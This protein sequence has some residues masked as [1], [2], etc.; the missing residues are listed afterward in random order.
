MKAS[1]RIIVS[2]II[3][4]AIMSVQAIAEPPPPQVLAG[5]V[6]ASNKKPATIPTSSTTSTSKP[7]SQGTNS[8]PPQIAALAD[9]AELA[10]Y[11]LRTAREVEIGL[12]S[13]AMIG[14][15][16]NKTTVLNGPVT[17][18]AIQQAISAANLQIDLSSLED[19]YYNVNVHDSNWKVSLWGGQSKKPVMGKAG[20]QA[21]FVIDLQL[22]SE[23]AI[24]WNGLRDVKLTSFD[25]K[26]KIANS[27]YLDVYPDGFRFPSDAAGKVLIEIT[28]Q[29]GKTISYD[30]RKSAQVKEERVSAVVTITAKNIESITDKSV[31]NLIPNTRNGVGD[32]VL[33]EIILTKET[34]V[35]VAAQTI[36][37]GKATAFKYMQ[38]GVDNDFRPAVPATNGIL[39]LKLTPGVWHII[40]IFP[41]DVLRPPEFIFSGYGGGNGGGKG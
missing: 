41:S 27:W 16:P 2:F 28:S 9:E 20:Y 17:L 4:T 31:L 11:A 5:S 38:V 15:A 7:I 35:S 18:P 37:N 23:V 10:S 24:L 39:F 25:S 34:D 12:Y 33:G 14:M 19:V 30:L 29:E 26:G 36:E 13:Q 1:Y 32:N 21:D 22:G 3:A 8:L 6:A 40:G